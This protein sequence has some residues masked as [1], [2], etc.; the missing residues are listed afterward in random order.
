MSQIQMRHVTHIIETCHR[1]DWKCIILG[2]IFRKKQYNKTSHT[3]KWDMKYFQ[4]RQVTHIIET[5]HRHDWKMYHTRIYVSQ[6]TTLKKKQVT[7]QN[8]TCHTSKRDMSHIKMRHAT[9]PNETCHTYNWIMPHTRL[10][11]VS[12]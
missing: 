10:K 3:S 12:Y 4:M 7:C 9:H 6:N 1:H 8:E 2:Y 11:D 5:C